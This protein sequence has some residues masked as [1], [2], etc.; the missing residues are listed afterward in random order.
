MKINTRKIALLAMFSVIALTIF[1]AESFIPPLLPIP[2]IKLGLANI[3]TLVVI[4]IYGPRDALC[5]LIVR[6]L[7][8][9]IFGG[10]MISF[11]YSLAGGLLCF[12][13]MSLLNRL[14]GG[15]FVIITSVFGAISHNIGQIATACVITQTAGVAAYLPVLMVSG[16]ITG[17]FTGAAAH[18]AIPRIKKIIYR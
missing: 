18:F 3:I 11:F 16:V 8:G 12:A 10:Q 14:L 9:S 13:V 2:G 6:I 7:L 15:H 17:C 5:V 4:A 1:V